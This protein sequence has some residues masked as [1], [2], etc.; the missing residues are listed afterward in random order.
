[1]KHKDAQFFPELDFD[2]VLK[3]NLGIM[4]ASAISLCRENGLEVRVINIFEH[5][6]LARLLKGEE[7]GSVVRARRDN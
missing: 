3:M 6:S 2:M 1:M 7:I 4:D 5:E